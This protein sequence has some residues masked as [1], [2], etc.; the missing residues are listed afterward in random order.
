MDFFRLNTIRGNKTAIVSPKK[1]NDG[2]A[3]GCSPPT[4]LELCGLL[5]TGTVR[6]FS[7]LCVYL[8]LLTKLITKFEKVFFGTI[9]CFRFQMIFRRSSLMFELKLKFHVQ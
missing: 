5:F 8:H 2:C 7:V 1:Y 9:T 6:R 3:P 4:N